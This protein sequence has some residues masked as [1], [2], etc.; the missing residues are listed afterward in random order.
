M[1]SNNNI[2]LKYHRLH[3]CKSYISCPFGLTAY[4]LFPL[5]WN[6]CLFFY[7]CISASICSLSSKSWGLL[8]TAGSEGNVVQR[9]CMLCIPTPIANMLLFTVSPA[10]IQN[11]ST[12][13]TGTSTGSISP[14]FQCLISRPAQ[15]ICTSL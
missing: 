10:T 8:E 5:S 3:E 7:I 9:N 13:S 4:S 11:G 2:S 1:I 6:L 12:R 14:P 15:I